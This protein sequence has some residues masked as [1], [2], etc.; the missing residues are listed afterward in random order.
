MIQLN[1]GIKLNKTHLLMPGLFTHTT[2][3]VTFSLVVVD[4]FGTKYGSK[5]DAEHLIETLKKWYTITIDWSGSLYCGLSLAWDYARRTV[6][7]SM[8]GYIARALS[9]FLHTAPTR[10][11]HLPHAWIPPSYGAAVQYALPDDVSPP[12]DAAALLHLQK[13]I[14]TLL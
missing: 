11:Q 1:L 10:A 6:D 13:V 2:R 9:T 7:V 12:L 5:A 4:D 8:P 14:G 3:P